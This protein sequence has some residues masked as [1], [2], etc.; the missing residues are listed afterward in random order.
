[1]Y[2]RCWFS[3]LLLYR[4]WAL[5]NANSIWKT[6]VQM[7]APPPDNYTPV[8][9]QTHQR[10][11]QIISFS[12]RSWMCCIMAMCVLDVGI[13]WGSLKFSIICQS[14]VLSSTKLG[15]A[16]LQ[17]QS[18]NLPHCCTQSNVIT[19]L[20]A[21]KSVSAASWHNVAL[22]LLSARDCLTADLHVWRATR[23]LMFPRGE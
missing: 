19:Q 9:F 3:V 7:L 8:F 15:P 5:I 1:M 2:S 21:K 22:V 4:Y 17:N 12:R 10:L 14:A 6:E 16:H 23:M 20:N 18:G 11:W 13:I